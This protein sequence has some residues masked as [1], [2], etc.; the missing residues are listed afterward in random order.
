MCGTTAVEQCFAAV[1]NPQAETF[2][3]F[4]DDQPVAM[5]GSAPWVELG[6]P[7]GMCILWFLGSNGLFH[8]KRDFLIQV[9]YWLDWLQRHYHT[10]FN[11]V[12]A[13]NHVSL[14]WCQS[15]GFQLG[16]TERRGPAGELFTFIFRKL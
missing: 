9:G 14:R 3:V 6:S 10:G 12:S 1:D 8:I 2:T 13:D 11:F 5:F 7:P 15:V 16:D 4:A